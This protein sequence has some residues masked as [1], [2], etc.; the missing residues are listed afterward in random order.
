MEQNLDF[1][2][3]QVVTFF[4][5]DGKPYGLTTTHI[6]TFLVMAVLTIFALIVRAKVKNFKTIPDTKFQIIIEFLV[7]TIYNFTSSTM[8]EKNRKFGAFY[9]PMFLFILLCNLTGLI[10]L[11]PPTADIATTF[12]LSLTTF[13][14]IHYF[15]LRSKGANY[16]KGFL[17]PIPL[18]LPL[19]IIGELANP[20][21]LSFRLFGNILG[22]TIIMGLYYAMMPWWA[23]LG[24]PSILHSY[25][26]VFAG[27]LQTLIF[28]MLSMTF[29]SSAME[30]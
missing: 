4:T 15:G 20:I 23:Q 24:L 16:L 1:G 29:V 19:N 5:I 12:A 13:F 10:G 8:G 27:A 30:E 26:D 22:G 11:R 2:I 9:G 21:S 14:M 25:F 6:N 28:V 7:D 3:H 17:E 18:L